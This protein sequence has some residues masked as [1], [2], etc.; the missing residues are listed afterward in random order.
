MCDLDPSCLKETKLMCMD[1]SGSLTD[2]PPP[3]L[4]DAHYA[5]VFIMSVEHTK[6]MFF[7][8]S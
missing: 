3:F 4:E 6:Y 2:N 8:V 5:P 7:K 1:P